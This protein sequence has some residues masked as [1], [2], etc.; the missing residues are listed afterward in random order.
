MRGRSHLTGIIAIALGVL[1]FVR[2]AVAENLV[3][4]L[5]T[6]TIQVTSDF[7]GINIALFGVVERDAQSVARG[8]AY[9]IA[10][11]VRGPPKDILVQRKARRFGIWVNA[12]G[13]R[14]EGI[15]AYSA[16]FTTAEPGAQLEMLMAAASAPSAGE[17]NLDGE[18]TYFYQAYA[19]ARTSD[20]LYV[21][22][23][24]G[25]EM[26]TDRFFRTLIPLPGLA[27]AGEY[28]VDVYLFVGGVLLDKHE[29]TFLVDKVGLE[30]KLYWLSRNQPLAYGLLVVLLALVTGYVGGVVF[31]RN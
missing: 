20:G 29:A 18:R 8:G 17:Q 7:T 16:L 13:E 10:V 3:V 6:D 22:D 23:I 31:R 25:V 27:P 4:D 24:G 30:Q 9:E 28:A 19:S 1:A 11:I 2:S 21:R 5:S 15:P 26:L 12:E 14:F